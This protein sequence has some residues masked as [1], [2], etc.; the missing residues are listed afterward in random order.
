MKTFLRV[1]S[2]GGASGDMILSALADAGADLERIAATI[3]SFFPEPVHFHAEP[4]SQSGIAG[5]RVS[6]HGPHAHDESVW[7]EEGHHHHHDHHDPVHHDHDHGHGDHHG[8]E[9]RAFSEI[10]ALLESAPLSDKVKELSLAVF[11]TIAEA[12]GKI[13]GRPVEEVHFHE[14]GAWDSV[15]DI[16]G[17]CLALE[18]LDIA[19]VSCGP[20]PSGSGTLRC[21]HGIMPNPAPAT[22]LLLKGMT[23]TQTDEP[24]ELVTPTG[25]ALLRVWTERLEP[26]P[27]ALAVAGEGI[28][29]GSRLLNN[30]P[31]LL[32]MTL[33]NTSKTECPTSDLFP[34]GSGDGTDG[35]LWMLETNLDDANPEWLGPLVDALLAAGAK[36][37]WYTPILMKKNRPATLL[38]VLAEG[39]GLTRLREM[40]FRATPTFGIRYYPVQREALERRFETVQTPYGPIPVKVGLLRGEAITR[41]PEFEACSAAAARAGVP[42]RAVYA[43]AQRA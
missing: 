10:R 14:V 20:L 5:I 11:T 41:S 21:A 9:H 31:N 39:A 40:I 25:A 13:H 16:V 37:V 19:G 30:R 43:A 7:M 29:F 42:V 32:R 18:Q 24:F 23:V 2:V 6:V 26:V 33:L 1:D 28:G 22:Q 35:G 8:H 27:A 34:S 17:A 15:A 3:A 38:S 36:D 12:E 4:V